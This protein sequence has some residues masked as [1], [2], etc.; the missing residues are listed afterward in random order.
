MPT[1]TEKRVP[2]WKRSNKA[3]WEKS[4][5]W[6]LRFLVV[7]L[8][9]IICL[10]TSEPKDIL[11]WGVVMGPTV[12]AIGIEMVDEAIR[13]RERWRHSIF[14][15]GVVLSLL[16]LWQQNNA[17]KTSAIDRERAIKET[18][19][20]VAVATSEHVTRVLTNQYTQLVADQKAQIQNL[21]TQ[22]SSRL[23]SQIETS[24]T[25]LTKALV[26]V[27]PGVLTHAKLQF[28]FFV[29]GKDD[30]PLTEEYFPREDDGSVNVR[31]W[32]KN[33]S[34]DTTTGKG[35]IWIQVCKGC[36]YAKEPIGFSKMQDLDE[37][38][39]HARIEFINA[40][41]HVEPTLLSV[42]PPAGESVF[43][44]AFK[45]SCEICGKVDSWQKLTV[46]TRS[47]SA[48]RVEKIKP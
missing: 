3:L 34:E 48:L 40:G 8:V 33:I 32:L 12:F 24:N 1:T 39:R 29:K 47:V 4:R 23:S 20:Q 44:I 10:E 30:F 11:D 5:L 31:F 14:A 26:R 25:M 45:Y 15:F 19:Q 17:K 41:I 22:L 6:I 35:D 18:S 2:L 16:T 9:V 43:E 38:V 37:H 13:K 42:K 28:S 21:E 27:N 36:T 46:H 7:I